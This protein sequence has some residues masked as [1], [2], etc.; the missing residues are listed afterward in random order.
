MQ[1]AP[2]GRPAM[3]GHTPVAQPERLLGAASTT[4]LVTAAMPERLLGA[5][6]TTE[7]V[8]AAVGLGKTALSVFFTQG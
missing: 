2:H 1:G 3:P 8:T 6:S 4:E 5:A 7:L